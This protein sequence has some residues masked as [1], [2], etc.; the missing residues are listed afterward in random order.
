[1]LKYYAWHGDNARDRAWPVGLLKPNDLGLFDMY[2]NAWEWCHERDS[3]DHRRLPED[4]EDTA[5]V[6]LAD[7]RVLRGGAFDCRPPTM[8]SAARFADRPNSRSHMVGLRVARTCPQPPIQ[9]AQELVGG[10]GP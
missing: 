8:R 2:G 5:R 4:R 7:D 1:M 6:V 3:L 9:A 10:N